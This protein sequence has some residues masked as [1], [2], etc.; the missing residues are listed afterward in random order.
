MRGY[1][2]KQSDGYFY[3]AISR[4]KRTAVLHEATLFPYIEN[5]Q[6]QGHGWNISMLSLEEAHD[7]SPELIEVVYDIKLNMV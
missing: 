1:I 4:T 3:S 5:E 7:Q 2:V 6:I